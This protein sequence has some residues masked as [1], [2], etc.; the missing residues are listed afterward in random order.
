MRTLRASAGRKS[1]RP[2]SPSASSRRA[3]SPGGPHRARLQVLQGAPSQ[4]PASR[5]RGSCP[6]TR[7]EG[8]GARRSSAEL[9]ETS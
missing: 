1:A 9:R 8:P 6:R 2:Q 3:G 4:S 5:P 7:W